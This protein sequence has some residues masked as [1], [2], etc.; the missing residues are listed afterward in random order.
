MVE[1]S[2][3]GE[4]VVR[5]ESQWE[6]SSLATTRIKGWLA[7]GRWNGP[8][9]SLCRPSGVVTVKVY[10]CHFDLYLCLELSE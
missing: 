4:V 1:Y 8:Q 9:H 2:R 5:E 7:G 6:E 3:L 10:T